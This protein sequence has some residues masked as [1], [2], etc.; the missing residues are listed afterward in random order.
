M[1]IT[2]ETRPI[3]RASTH[4]PVGVLAIG[5]VA[6]LGAGAVHA[7]AIGAHGEHRAAVWTF[8]AL[9]LL[10]LA[11]GA[12]VLTRSSRR[13]A[14]AGAVLGGG[15]VAGWVLAKTSGIGF[16][17]GLDR[18]EPI[19]VA[20]T[21]AAALAAV[22]TGAAVTSLARSY[23]GRMPTLSAIGMVAAGGHHHDGSGA[24]HVHAAAAVAP[25]PYDPALPIDLSGVAGVTPQQQARAE[26][27]V[28]TTLARL[29]QFADPEAAVAAGFRSLHD[30]G[31]GFEHYLNPA[32]IRDRVILDPDHPESIVYDVRGGGK[33]LVSAMFMLPP[34]ATL[35]DVP[36]IG[37]ALTQWHV[38]DNLCFSRATGTIAGLTDAKG[39]CPAPLVKGPAM[40]MI[41]VW[42][43]PNPCGPFAALEG[44]AAGSIK[45]GETRLC[46]HLHGAPTPTGSGALGPAVVS[47]STGE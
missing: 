25:H 34:D 18:V 13:L 42:I 3:A 5:G 41:H 19:Q 31:T 46:D 38:H 4:V 15:A 27:L 14:V 20:D 30:G 6:S 43:T 23:R 44:I 16:I 33:K 21:I 8:A 9:A 28:A 11:W 1:A 26:N 37:G 39:A 7:A 32:Y 24:T 36:D 35:D 10:Q 12:T 45:A 40:P 22:A 47:S 2:L 17:P 29:P